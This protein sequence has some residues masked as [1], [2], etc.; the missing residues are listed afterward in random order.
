MNSL[1]IELAIVNHLDYRVNTIVPNVSY[2]LNF[3]EIDLLVL[4]QS[5][6]ATEIEIKTSVADLKADLNK[7]HHHNSNRIKLFYFAVP[8]EIKE[9]AL[10]LIPE[11]AGLYV[12]IHNKERGYTYVKCIKAPTVNKLARKFNNE[13]IVK[14]HKLGM[15]RIWSLKQILFDRLKQIKELRQV[16]K[17]D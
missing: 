2:G 12:V 9:K 10:E 1:E 11:R 16:K 8:E 13:E 7:K 4:S 5:G 6:Y 14:L 15:M 3:H 17:E